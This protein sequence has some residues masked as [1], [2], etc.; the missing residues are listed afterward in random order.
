MMLLVMG[1]VRSRALGGEPRDHAN[2]YL[3]QLSNVFTSA[4]VNVGD[5]RKALANGAAGLRSYIEAAIQG[6]EPSDGCGDGQLIIDLFGK[7]V[8]V[9]PA[10][11]RSVVEGG[12][13]ARDGYKTIVSALDDYVARLGA[14]SMDKEQLMTTLLTIGRLV[15]SYVPYSTCGVGSGI[16][17]YAVMH[18]AAAYASTEPYG[19]FRLLG[20]DILGIQEVIGRIQRTGQAMRQLRGR[21]VLVNLFQNAVA[22]RI[23]R[24]VN[25][26]VGSDV[27][28]PINVLVNTGGEVVMLIPGLDSNVLDY[29]IND[30]ESKVNEEFEGRV[31]VVVAYTGIHDIG[32][33]FGDVLRELV[34]ALGRRRYGIWRRFSVGGKHLCSMCGMP[35]GKLSVETI[36]GE[37][38][39]L[40]PFCHYSHRVGT[41]SRR[42]GFMAEL[43]DSGGYGGC[44]VIELLGI[45]YAVCPDNAR[46]DL[47]REYIH[48]GIN[49]FQN[50][51]LRASNVGYSVLFLNTRMPISQDTGDLLT[52][53][54]IGNYAIS[55]K[56]DANKMGI[57]KKG[58][59]ERGAAAYLF[60]STLLTTVFDAYGPWLFTQNLGRYGNN[61]FIIYSGGDDIFIAGDHRAL[62]YI[63]RVMRRALDFGISVAAGAL[64][65][66]P[67]MPMYLVWDE[68]DERLEAVKDVSRDEPLIYLAHTGSAPII[69]TPSDVLEVVDY[70]NANTAAPPGEYEGDVIGKSLMFKVGEELTNI[71][72]M[73][74][75]LYALARQGRCGS[76]NELVRELVRGVV[77]YTYLVNRNRDRAYAVINEISSNVEPGRLTNAL[78]P[79]L[80]IRDCS[81]YVRSRELTELMKS[82]AKAIMKIDLYR[83]I[84]RQ[85]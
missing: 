11:M 38:L 22:V 34:A 80:R 21:S 24:D 35:T 83:K 53:E 51:I 19:R 63:A 70:V 7:E 37:E 78:M 55:V 14:L 4:G 9:G 85:T 67:Q 2:K 66:E 46:A 32:N 41:A 17:A 12:V 65:H 39:R 16:S 60:F 42:L 6:P 26:R 75:A 48:Y 73:L 76:R 47:G 15:L 31:R 77:N 20:V 8:R 56:A 62:D 44:E 28:S 50:P 3:E 84:S 45:R 61:V 43:R 13:S 82:L 57:F 23:I 58:A 72:N 68:T 81:E 1:R 74:Y 5:V 10:L 59:A 54:D 49:E 40:C 18:T 30:I 79:I 64:I 25:R 36:G 33:R 29:V 52:L 27:L 69:L 71:Y